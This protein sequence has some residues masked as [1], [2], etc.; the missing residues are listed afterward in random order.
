MLPAHR[1]FSKGK[2]NF[3]TAGRAEDILQHHAVRLGRILH[4]M[5]TEPTSLE[6][7]TRGVFARRKLIGGNLYMALSGDSG[8]YRAAGGCGGPGGVGGYAAAIEGERELP[9]ADCGVGV[10]L[11]E[12]VYS[13]PVWSSST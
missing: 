3:E 4:R 10:G 6:H 7:I 2:F 11:T 1:L 13:G 12:A 9:G 8:A 5:G